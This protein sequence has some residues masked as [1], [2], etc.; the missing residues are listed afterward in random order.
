MTSQQVVFLEK[1]A[2]NLLSTVLDTPEFF[3]DAPDSLQGLYDA[4]CEYLEMEDRVQVRRTP[5]NFKEPLLNF[6]D[7]IETPTELGRRLLR[8]QVL[9][10]R[11]EVLRDLLEVLRDHQN[12]EHS[13]MLEWIVIVL[14][15]VEIVIGL[16]EIAGLVGWF[17]SDR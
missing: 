12:N 10:A 14:I 11:F 7:A 1:C 9:N 17:G 16:V 2:V 3:W 5:L 15:V 6:K 4:L 8:V 13:S